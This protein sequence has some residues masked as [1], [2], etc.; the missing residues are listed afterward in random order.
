MRILW[1]NSDLRLIDLLQQPAAPHAPEAQSVE[2]YK[3]S[4]SVGAFPCHPLKRCIFILMF[5]CSTD[6]YTGRLDLPFFFTEFKIL[7]TK[8]KSLNF[9]HSS[10]VMNFS[11]VDYSYMYVLLLKFS[12][13][14]IKYLDQIDPNSLLSDSFHYTSPPIF[15]PNT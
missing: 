6:F 10:Q 13:M 8:K 12:Y 7:F 2:K 5:V 9:S 15:L 3:V 4:A 14:H 1:T 11:Q